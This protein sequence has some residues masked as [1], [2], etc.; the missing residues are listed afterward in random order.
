MCVDEAHERT[1]DTDLLLGRLKSIVDS[2]EEAATD[3][4]DQLP[5]S[6]THGLRVV[7]MSATLDPALFQNYFT[8]YPE[9]V[10]RVPTLLRVCMCSH[11]PFD[12]N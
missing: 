7:V 9:G 10:A 8:N 12:F 6:S 5:Q 2:A 3:D 4:R 1:V 11:R